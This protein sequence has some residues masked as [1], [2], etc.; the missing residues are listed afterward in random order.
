MRSE[1]AKTHQFEDA[2]LA[3]VESFADLPALAAEGQLCFVKGEDVVYVY[4]SQRWRRA[5]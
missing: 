1:T 2:W 3:P 5:D 4:A